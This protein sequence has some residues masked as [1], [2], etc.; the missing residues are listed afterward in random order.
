MRTFTTGLFLFVALVLASSSVAPVSASSQD[1]AVKKGHGVAGLFRAPVTFRG[2]RLSLRWNFEDPLEAED[3]ENVSMFAVP[4]RANFAIRDGELAADGAGAFMLRACFRSES[5]TMSFHIRPGL[6]AQ[7]MGAMMAEP[8]ELANHLLFTLGNA[9]FK[10]DKGANAYAAPGHLIFVFGKGMWARG[11]ADQIG[12]VR[13]GFSEEPKL[14]P[15]E[16]VEIECSKEK[17]KAKFV[18]DGKVI[19]GRSIGDNKYEFTGVRPALFVLLSEARFDELT[20]EGEIDPA[21]ALSERARLFP[22]PR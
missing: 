20:V 4:T 18:V 7:D 19:Q 12:F 2:N 11:D 10:L 3:F 21:W 16:W 8:K 9:Y 14:K 1:D 15:R 13:T 6:P 17:D 5:V 22:E